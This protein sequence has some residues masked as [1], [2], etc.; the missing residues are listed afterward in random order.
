M[1]SLPEVHGCDV[2]SFSPRGVIG[3]QR[4]TLPDLQASLGDGRLH[5]ELA[6]MESSA[7][8]TFPFL[9]IESTLRRTTSGELLDSTLTIDAVRSVIA[10][11]AGFGVGYLPSSDPAD[12]WRTIT[13]VGDYVA[14]D[15]FNAIRR[16]KQLRNEWGTISSSSFGEFFL[17]SFPGIGPV[18]ARNIYA[19]FGGV[20]V[21]WTVSEEELSAVKG[22]GSKTA[23]KLMQALTPIVDED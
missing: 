19:H 20:P 23:Q 4:K 11:F 9:I 7:T 10:K 15:S 21:T 6:Q 1:S 5:Y 13:R 8:V 2:L 22:I 14:S 16:P 3:Y 12:T 18:G 17:Q